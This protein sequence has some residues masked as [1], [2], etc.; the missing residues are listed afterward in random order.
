MNAHRSVAKLPGL[1]VRLSRLTGLAR[2][3][4]LLTLVGCANW[5]QSAAERADELF[6]Q[7]DRP[8]SPGAA[9]A[10][11]RDGKLI[12]ANAFG[13]SHLDYGAPNT[14]DTLFEVGSMSKSFMS[15]LVARLMD[16]E[17][18]APDDDIRKYLPELQKVDPPIRIRH[19]LRCR[20]GVWAQWH[21]VQLAGWSSEPIES[22]YTKEDL[23]GLYA[24]QK[25]FPFEPGEE[26]LYGS[27]DFF[28]SG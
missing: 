24:K 5:P 11:V 22:P 14:P 28:Y 4:T 10:I 8:D 27:G 1:S 3:L 16:D 18:V 23:F 2:L 25:T 13:T 17:K 21:I 6:A 15:A 19:L 26:F 20:S 9:I 7:W 12:H